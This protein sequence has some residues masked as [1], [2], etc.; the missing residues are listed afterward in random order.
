MPRRVDGEAWVA[1]AGLGLAGVGWSLHAT[2]LALAGTLAAMTALTLWIWQ[3]QC[4]TG[5]TYRRTLRQHRATFGEEVPLDIE[6]VNDKVL[7][8]TWLHV[9]DEVPRDLTVRGGTIVFDRSGPHHELHYLLPMLPFQRVRRTLTVVCDRRGEHVFGPA[10]LRSGDPVG[11]HERFAGMRDQEQLLVYPKVFRLG[12]LPVASRVPLG[13]D[14]ATLALVG[15]PSRTA[16]VREY[17][18]GDPLRHIDW[19]ATARGGSLLVRVFEP[20]AALR[21]AVFLDMRTP[22]VRAPGAGLDGLEFTVAVGASVVADLTGRGVATGLYC[23]GSV[24]GRSVAREPSS[25]PTALAAMLEL[26]ARASP[27]GPSSIAQLLAAEG[28]RLRR[29]A[30]VLV[31]AADYPEPTLVAIAGLRRRLPVTAVWVATGQGRPPPAELVDVRREVRYVD[32]WKQAD[33]VDLLV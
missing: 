26:L 27:H 25:S 30:S 23:S 1:A 32:G 12:A 18:D 28:A 8:L 11:L 14:R 29:G 31:V 24:R 4:L 21:V 2:L 5:V 7:P 10:R 6:L 22:S 15:D 20:T 19:R 13:D 17:R 9:E 16:G 33:V 3:R